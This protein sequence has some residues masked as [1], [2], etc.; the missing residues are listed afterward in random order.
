MSLNHKKRPDK[1]GGIKAGFGN[2]TTRKCGHPVAPHPCG[3]VLTSAHG[4]FNP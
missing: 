3:R 1:I 2:K 4:L